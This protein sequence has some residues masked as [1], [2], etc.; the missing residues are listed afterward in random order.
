MYAI[1]TIDIFRI[2]L[3]L[4][5]CYKI[6]Y[7]CYTLRIWISMIVLDYQGNND[8]EMMAVGQKQV[9]NTNPKDL[10]VCNALRG[11]QVSKYDKL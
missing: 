7:I 10:L 4:I 5:T 1:I 3:C 6:V 8:K 2:I 9:I 11:L